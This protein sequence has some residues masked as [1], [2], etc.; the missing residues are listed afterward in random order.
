MSIARHSKAEHIVYYTWP[1]L[2]FS[3]KRCFPCGVS[4]MTFKNNLSDL[5]D[6]KTACKLVF[7]DERNFGIVLFSFLMWAQEAS[8]FLQRENFYNILPRKV[9]ACAD[10]NGQ[11]FVTP[12][13]DLL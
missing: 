5:L 4:S 2:Q 8:S 13:L 11:K 6:K 7:N 9:L 12:W 3:E 1:V 10:L